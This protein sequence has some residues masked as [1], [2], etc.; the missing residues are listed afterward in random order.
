[1]TSDSR[2]A[3][4]ERLTAA[5]DRPGWV[6]EANAVNWLDPPYNRAGFLQVDRLTS[7]VPVSRGRGP[8][9]PLPRDPLGLS[10]FRLEV[11]SRVLDFDTWFDET[12]TDGLMVIH[13]GATV[14]E[15]YGGLMVETDRHLLM[16]VSKSVTSLLC[17]VLVGRGD[18][19]VTDVVTDHLTELTSTAWEGCTVEHLLDM[20][21]GISWDYHRDEVDI[22]DV[23]GYRL[24]SRTDLPSNTASWIRTIEASKPHGGSMRYIS[25]VTDVLGWVLERATGR[26]LEDLIS[27]HLWSPIGAEH[28][29]SIIIDAA[30]FRV[31]EGGLSSTLRDIGRLGLMCL[32]RGEIEGRQIVPAEWFERLATRRDDLIGMFAASQDGDH[33][34]PH[35]FYH[36]NW[37]ITDAQQGEFSAIGIHGQRLTVHRPSQTVVV[38][39]SSQP[40]MEDSALVALDTRGIDAICSALGSM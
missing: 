17:G 19:T 27:E 6:P 3:I 37:W 11:D 31:A 29:G 25:L 18:V 9:A 38:K 22:M 36:D 23:S 39:F 28:D 20:T 4:A 32:Q 12:F 13:D 2:S 34:T 24:T 1:M 7:V 5:M 35:A 8:I 30:G 15:R 21:A 26:R 10:G 40:V 16:S 14:V 33:A